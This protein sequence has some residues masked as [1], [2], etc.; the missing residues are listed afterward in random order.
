VT[1]YANS[2]RKKAMQG[3]KGATDSSTNASG[4]EPP[5]KADTGTSGD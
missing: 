3:E 5:A 4:T 2:E 1:D